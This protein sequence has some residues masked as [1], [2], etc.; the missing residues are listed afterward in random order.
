MNDR[1]LTIY[2]AIYCKLSSNFRKKG[3]VNFFSK[4]N[5]FLTLY[6]INHLG[7]IYCFPLVTVKIKIFR[8]RRMKQASR[9]QQ[10]WL[11]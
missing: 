1:Y 5:F 2:H 3:P 9:R 10:W 11:E 7:K 8:K 4:E 6:I